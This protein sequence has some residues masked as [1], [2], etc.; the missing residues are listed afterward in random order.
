[1]HSFKFFNVLTMF[2][3]MC[4]ELWINAIESVSDNLKVNQDGRAQGDENGKKPATHKVVSCI[5]SI[6]NFRNN[7]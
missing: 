2:F 4:R 1:M 5:L 3:D 7:F 6:L